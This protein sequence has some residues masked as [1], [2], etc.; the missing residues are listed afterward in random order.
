MRGEPGWTFDVEGQEALDLAGGGS[1][2]SYRATV[3]RTGESE[4][5]HSSGTV[6]SKGSSTPEEVFVVD[7]VGYVR[8]GEGAWES[9]DVSDP[10]IANKVEDPVAALDVFR[11]YSKGGERISVAHEGGGITLRVEVPSGKLSDDRPALAKAVREVRPTIEQLREGGVTATDSEIVLTRLADVLVLDQDTYR[12]KSHRFSFGFTIP[13]QGQQITY[14]Q[15]VGEENRGV[16][17]GDITLPDG[18]A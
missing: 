10:E 1:E 16:F 7:G 9:G 11:A 14:R 4:A 5:L 2:A 3:R 13:Y 8:E 6:V 15:E 18:V 17:T 12:I